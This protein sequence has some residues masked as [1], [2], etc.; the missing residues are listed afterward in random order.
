MA[1]SLD[2]PGPC[3]ARD[4]YGNFT[5]LGHIAKSINDSGATAAEILAQHR[6]GVSR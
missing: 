2:P 6:E 4:E 1:L 5:I 3:E